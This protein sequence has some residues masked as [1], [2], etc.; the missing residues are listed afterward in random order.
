L[1]DLER[2][3]A[4][5]IIGKIAKE[6]TKADGTEDDIPV[7]VTE[8]EDCMRAI[9]GMQPRTVADITVKSPAV[10]TVT[11]IKVTMRRI[12]RE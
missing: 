7:G 4:V 9:A 11:M 3:S 12:C 10:I 1:R 2:N 6:G 8:G 5:L